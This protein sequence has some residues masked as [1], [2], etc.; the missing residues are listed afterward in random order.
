MSHSLP[1]VFF[2]GTQCDERL[3]LPVWRE[4]TIAD[5]R[6]IP[7]QWAETLEQMDG[8]TEHAVA[9]DK[10][11]LVAFSMGGYIACRFALA[12]P[13]QVASL[14]LIGFCSA[15][16]NQQ[17]LQQRQL[18]IR[19]L[20]KGQFRPMSAQ[21]LAM[22]VNPHSPNHQFA[23]QV[24]REMEQDLGGSVLKY[25]LIAASS[26]PDLT[27][28]LA[29]AAFPV[30]IIASECDEVAALGAMQTMH[31]AIKHS[32]MQVFSGAGHMLPL[33]QPKALSLHLQSRI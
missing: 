15:G 8:L 10:V 29:Q 1:V 13:D 14:T 33:E 3:W 17:E 6:Y 11:H 19:A 18:I 24:V 28:D 26:R 25:H 5:R 7:L 4:M 9:G 22:M 20:D 27:E 2:P 21:R 12:N 23:Q 16:L 32:S 31:Q 30:H